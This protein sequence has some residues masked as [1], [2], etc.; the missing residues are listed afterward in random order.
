MYTEYRGKKSRTVPPFPRRPTPLWAVA[1]V[2]GN[3]ART[4][5]NTVKSALPNESVR[6]N[7]VFSRTSGSPRCDANLVPADVHYGGI[8]SR[9]HRRPP[10]PSVPALAREIPAEF[11]RFFPPLSFRGTQAPWTRKSDA[12]LLREDTPTLIYCIPRIIPRSFCCPLSPTECQAC[13]YLIT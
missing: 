8:P 2:R 13:A 1:F 11:P 10:P 7:V 6:R 5:P 4:S 9:K 12:N 3:R